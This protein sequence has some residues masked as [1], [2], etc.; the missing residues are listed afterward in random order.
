MAETLS[1][2]T[3]FPEELVEGL[4]S[5]VNGKSSLAKLSG[6]IPVAF[7]GNEYF[8][9]NMDDEVQIVGENQ[10]K[11]AGKMTIKPIMHRPFKVEYGARVSDEFKYGA[12]DVKIDILRA[13]SEG[14]AK[15]LARALD[16]MA[17]HGINPRTGEAS[18]LIGDNNF[19]A[20]VTQKVIFDATNPDANIQAA[21][22]LIQGSERDVDG[23][24]LSP[25]FSSA[26]ANLKVNGVKQFPEF[27]WGQVP[28]NTNG[29][30][31]DINSTVS[32]AKSKT[33]AL[34]GD[35]GAYFKWGYAKEIPME[36]I[37]Y[38]DPD[39]SGSDLKAHNQVYIRCE[40]YLGWALMDP[41]SFA[42]V[43]TEA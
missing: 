14:Y 6:Q 28:N 26:L 35:F 40:T 30:R 18:T 25:A 20:Q 23:L 39:Q 19:D 42:R 21:V 37:P 5:K 38:G 33:R 22:D 10:P 15:K 43:V 12:Q 2:G 36:V 11:P 29:L 17:I 9:F 13:F 27:S 8:V 31:V 24:I 3:L 4:F 16:L 34:I 32:A 41:E 7:N 1:R